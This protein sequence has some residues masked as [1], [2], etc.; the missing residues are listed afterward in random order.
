MRARASAAAAAAARPHPLTRSAS[1]LAHTPPHALPP[2]PQGHDDDAVAL[3][4]RAHAVDQAAL[5]SD[6]VRCGRHLLALGQAYARQ[7]KRDAA[8]LTLEEARSIFVAAL[9][10]EQEATKTATAAIRKLDVL[11]VDM[12]LQRTDGAATA[13]GS[14]FVSR[15]EARL[16]A[17]SAKKEARRDDLAA[18]LAA[19]GDGSATARAGGGAGGALTARPGRRLNRGYGGAAGGARAAD[20]SAE[21]AA[22]KAAQ[23]AA[24]ASRRQLAR[25]AAAADGGRGGSDDDDDDDDDDD[26]GA[27]AAADG[28]G[29]EDAALL[30]E[31]ESRMAEVLAATISKAQRREGWAAVVDGAVEIER[32]VGGLGRARASAGAAAALRVL[33]NGLRS[34]SSDEARSLAALA[35]LM[36][37]EWCVPALDAPFRRQLAAERWLRRLSDLARKDDSD[38]ALVRGALLQ[39]L[40]NWADWYEDEPAAAGFGAARDALE[41]D[42]F[43]L[44]PP[45]PRPGADDGADGGGGARGG[46]GGGGGGAPLGGRAGGG[47]VADGELEGEL[48]VMR[49]DCERLVQA[50]GQS[51]G[52]TALSAA[53]LAEATQAAQDCRGWLKRLD[54][55]LATPSGGAAAGGATVRATAGASAARVSAAMRPR[56]AALRAS[57][58][59]ALDRWEA[60]APLE[61]KLASTRAALRSA[62]AAAGGGGGLAGGGGGATPRTRALFAGAG[63]TSRML[64]RASSSLA[65][66]A[67]HTPRLRGKPK[68]GGGKGA[69][70]RGGRRGDRSARRGPA[71]PEEDGA[72]VAESP[73]YRGLRGGDSTDDD[74]DDDGGDGPALPLRGIG[75]VGKRHS[76]V[77][78]SQPL[79][80]VAARRQSMARPK[81]ALDLSSAQQL[82]AGDL[83]KTSDDDDDDDDD[84]DGDDGDDGESAG[85]DELVQELA[86]L[87]MQADSWKA[88]WQNAAADNERLRDAL[89]DARAALD[90]RACG[91]GA[92]AGGGGDAAAAA[93]AA[94]RKADEA[95]AGVGGGSLPVSL[96][97]AAEHTPERWRELC[98]QLSRAAGDERASLLDEIARLRAE[99]DAQ[100]GALEAASAARDAA[101]TAAKAAAAAAAASQG[102]AEREQAARAQLERDAAKAARERAE[103]AADAQADGAEEAREAL[104]EARADAA[105]T[106][107]ELVRVRSELDAKLTAACAQHKADADAAVRALDGARDELGGALAAAA[108][109]KAQWEVLNAEAASSSAA[110]PADAQHLAALG[111]EAAELGERVRE[112]E[113]AAEQA[114]AAAEAKAAAL[115]EQVESLTFRLGETAAM[116]RN[117][118]AALKRE[119]KA[120][121]DAEA[122]MAEAREACDDLEKEL[123]AKEETQGKEL[124]A[125]RVAGGQ[126]AAALAARAEAVAALEAQLAAAHEGASA[127]E[128]RATEFARKYGHEFFLR[129]QL[130]NQL[131]EM[132][133]NLR[134][135]CRV[136]PPN[137]HELVVD[138]ANGAAVGV[139]DETSLV[140]SDKDDARNPLRRYEYN[141]VYGAGSTQEE[142][143]RDTEPLMT[144]VLDGFNVCIFAYGQSGSGKTYTMEGTADA[145]GLVLRAVSRLFEVVAERAE[146]GF[147]TTLYLGMVEIYNETLKDLLAPKA[148]DAAAAAAAAPPKKLEILKDSLLGMYVKDLTSVTVHTASHVRTL[149]AQGNESRRTMATGLNEQSS[150]SHMVVTLVSRTTNAQTGES[151]VGKLSLVDLAGSERLS[152]SETTGEA[153]KESMAINKSLTTLGT[154][155]AALANG[156]KHVPFRDS[157]LTYLLQDS[158]GG[159]S[160]TLMMVNVSPSQYNV[161]E[162]INSLLFANRAKSVALGKATKNR[163]AAQAAVNKVSTTLGALQQQAGEPAAAASG[164]GG[165]AAKVAPAA[166]ARAGGPAGSGASP[167]R[168]GTTNGAGAKGGKPTGGGGTV[169]AAKR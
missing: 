26:G 48:A 142:V 119:A 4:N 143:F 7:G 115:E 109:W 49:E 158:L 64:Q 61:R 160:K 40:A 155:I 23:A 113:R 43:R 96:P 34:G 87:Q 32:L 90:A 120:R 91:A 149:I 11:E 20:D 58:A 1:T 16:A 76:V 92:G 86:L 80:G 28:G 126:A 45:Q 114:A 42:G 62:A 67:T 89:T 82:R 106:A 38:K 53:L 168:P 54:A 65:T 33:G 133:G 17:I 10:A 156:E 150:R 148:N 147:E 66:R 98:A 69:K 83:T 127:A 94:A 122:A 2:P 128:A 162:T 136:R 41:A 99:F 3:Y 138:G 71:E 154:V 125:L 164:G 135:Y 78:F 50:V 166:A 70:A 163:E 59:A 79:P 29:A 107:A 81:I 44:P 52:G 110:A 95:L 21:L 9:G 15:M 117:A 118:A 141:M 165:G 88:E 97:P 18:E 145:P 8:K 132:V 108:R 63:S 161:K 22:Q 130:H 35:V 151:W 51:Q 24:I 46:G 103:R 124:A 153:A 25:A 84:D 75:G 140:V 60:L 102:L 19:G 12:G 159:N 169:V 6:H 72:A 123:E 105:D 152:K 116:A 36:V 157:K 37:L 93:A 73:R 137:A 167:A 14:A 100:R 57:M 139:P 30:A 68:G 31:A 77:A 144:S 134:V 27:A 74:D 39:L 101:Q 131:Q 55:F 104:E 146:Q 85:E 5:G 121:E 13:R 129:K 47:D 111:A 112:L 56:L